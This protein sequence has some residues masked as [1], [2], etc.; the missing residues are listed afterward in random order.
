MFKKY[1]INEEF[2][3]TWTEDSAYVLGWVLTDGCIQY[4]P[5][6]KYAIRFELK[7]LEAI[8]TIRECIGSNSQIFERKDKINPLYLIV[9]NSKKLIKDLLDLG[10]TPS[11]TKRLRLIN[12]PEEFMKHLILGIFDGDGSVY[13]KNSK[14]NK[15]LTSYIC[16]SSKEFLVDIGNFLKERIEIIPKIYEDSPGFYKLRFGGKESYALYYYMYKDSKRFLSRKKEIFENALK[17]GIATGLAKCIGC[18]KEIIRT[19]NRTKWCFDCNIKV[20]KDRESKRT[21]IRRIQRR[22]TKLEN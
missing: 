21:E 6:K 16:S 22:H 10:V 7:D 15:L 11:K 18:G 3:E 5:N 13:V 20:H 8:N 9:L 17:E 19:S 2:F 1:S 4:I 14:K 12:I